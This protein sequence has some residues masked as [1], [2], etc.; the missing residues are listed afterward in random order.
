MHL[1]DLH[2]YL[3]KK[4]VIMSQ[5]CS[6]MRDFHTPVPSLAELTALCEKLHRQ[7]S[8]AEEEKYDLEVK[9]QN[10]DAEVFISCVTLYLT[11]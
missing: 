9:L 7:V 3:A 4:A 6:L 2:Y 8:Q 5:L 10:Q 11:L 1:L